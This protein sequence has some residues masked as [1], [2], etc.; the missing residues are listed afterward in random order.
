LETGNIFFFQA[1]EYN[2]TVNQLF[3]D[4]KKACDSV[5]KGVVCSILIEFGVSMKKAR[6]TKMCLSET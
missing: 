1:R 3:I 2:E 4:F 6:L 5:R